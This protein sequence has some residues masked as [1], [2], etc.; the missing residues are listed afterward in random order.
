[1][2]SPDQI[3]A[4]FFAGLIS[5]FA[6]CCLPLFPSYFSVISGFTFADLY[7][8]D[9]GKIRL[10]VFVS[11]LFFIAGFSLVF[12]I[13]GVTSSIVG[14]LLDTYLPVLLRLSGL[15]LVGLGL[16]QLGVVKV[17]TFQFDFAWNIQRR[18][19]RLGHVTALATGVAAAL[20]WIP[21]IGPLLT[22]ILLL[23]AR[24]ET[25]FQ[26]GFLLFIYSAGLTLP[27]LAAGL[28]FPSVVRKLEDN[29]QLFHRLSQASGIFLIL[30]GFILLFDKYQ[31]ALEK[32]YDGVGYILRLGEF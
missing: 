16:V 12:T 6:P 19:T 25:A 29:R 14:Q 10:R 28:F 20:S 22:P 17:S 11:S 27:F 4:S 15:F 8:L 18:L 30:F 3:I 1:M 24:T 13:L 23:S 2:I 5:F 9:F 7:G 31:L 32:F 21:C 26:G